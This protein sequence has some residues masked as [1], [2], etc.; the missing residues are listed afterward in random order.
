MSYRDDFT[1]YANNK[2]YNELN[3]RIFISRFNSF[4]FWNVCTYLFMLSPSFLFS[5]QE[6]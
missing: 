4:F 1:F 2:T 5:P 3:F 6:K